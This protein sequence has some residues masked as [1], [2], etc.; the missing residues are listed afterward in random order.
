MLV[1]RGL[2]SFLCVALAEWSNDKAKHN[3]LFL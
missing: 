3:G 1:K 2:L